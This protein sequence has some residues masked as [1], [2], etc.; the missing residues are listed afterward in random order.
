M[1]GN[2][3]LYKCDEH[4]IDN[5]NAALRTLGVGGIAED[6]LDAGLGSFNSDHD[7]SDSSAAVGFRTVSRSV[8]FS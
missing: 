3:T 7:V 8:S 2:T 4:V 5:W 6:G 1:G